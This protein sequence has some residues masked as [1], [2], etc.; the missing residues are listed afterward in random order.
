MSPPERPDERESSEALDLFEAFL[1]RFHEGGPGSQS[2]EAFCE[3]HPS[4]ADRFR[5][6]WERLSEIGEVGDAGEEDE[7][8]LPGPG[9]RFGPYFILKELGR[10]AQG[11]V[12]LAEEVELGRKVAL[13]LLPLHRGFFRGYKGRF[14]R[15][16]ELASKLDHPGLCTLYGRGS[17]QGVSYMAM[18]YV[19]GQSLAEKIASSQR[20]FEEGLGLPGRVE[21]EAYLEIFAKAAEALHVAHESG[22]IHRDLK[23]GNI[24]VNAKGEPV[25]VDFGLAREMESDSSLTATGDLV[26]TPAYI[27]PEQLASGRVVLDRRTDVYSLTATLFECLTLSRVFDAATRHQLY[28]QVLHSEPPPARSLNPAIS[29]DLEVLLAT[30]LQKER[31]M[32]YETARDLAEDLQRLQRNEPI[33]ARPLR[34]LQRL[35]RWTRRNPAIALSLAGVFLSLCAAL[36]FSLLF[37]TETKKARAAFEK[38]SDRVVLETLVKEAKGLRPVRAALLPKIQ[39]WMSRAQSLIDRLPEH[40][41]ALVALRTRA[42]PYDE[43]SRERDRQSHPRYGEFVRLSEMVPFLEQKLQE[44]LNGPQARFL[45]AKLR[46]Y[47]TKIQN[48][49]LELDRQRSFAFVSSEDRVAHEA[50]QKLVVDLDR[51]T[52]KGGTFFRMSQHLH[53]LQR[54]PLDPIPGFAEAWRHVRKRIQNNPR[55]QGRELRVQEG[56]L[57]LG[58]NPKTGLEE[59]LHLRSCSFPFPLPQRDQERGSFDLQA[60]HGL[61][62]ILLPA[63][64]FQTGPP[65]A[66]GPKVSLDWF[67]FS[68]YELNRSQWERLSWTAHPKSIL[69]EDWPSKGGESYPVE[70]ASWDQAQDLLSSYGLDL[71]TEYQWEYGARGGTLTRWWWGNARPSLLAKKAPDNF[72]DRSFVSLFK[73]RTRLLW[74]DHFPLLAPVDA[75]QPNPFGLHQVYGNVAEWCRDPFLLSLNLK[76]PLLP[77]EGVRK[78]PYLGLR[79]I[80]GGRFD[81]SPQQTGSWNRMG[82]QGHFGHMGVGFRP[83]RRV[84]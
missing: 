44:T 83:I 53:W 31:E 6:W 37:L 3:E 72:R 9:R 30:G 57:P 7:D 39:N 69:F 47:K 62:L 22:L 66:P 67:F 52:S 10:G 25:V 33:R 56:L 74:N 63:A 35:H 26:G 73:G 17:I 55:Y 68:A 24:L 79:V 5:K 71:P 23:P 11:A 27:S 15:E 75:G 41:R 45:Q 76:A 19:E 82:R 18:R 40:R 60:S 46:A 28:Q 80:K 84:E 49:H 78:I 58:L 1:L 12:Y 43:K 2:I 13:K 51:F 42:L 4:H 21:I 81:S 32:R 77:G 38:L 59:F 50:L 16:A 8:D 20:R 54:N 48:L 36:G 65:S 61:I 34:P 29:R 64:E 14:A 70:S